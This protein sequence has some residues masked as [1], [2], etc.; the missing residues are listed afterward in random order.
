MAK[1]KVLLPVFPGSNCEYDTVRQFE[2]YGAEAETCIIANLTPALVED[3]VQRLAAAIRQSQIIMLPGGFSGGDEPDG[4]GKFIA[5]FF[6]NPRIKEAVME[7]LQQRDGLMLGI[8]NGFQA[9]V[10]LGLLPYGEICDMTAQSPTL[11]YNNIGRHQS[12]LV[13]TRIASIKS[14]WLAYTEVGDIHAIPISHGEGKFVASP[15]DLERMA[16]GGQI[17]TQYVDMNGQPT[18]LTPYN[19]NASVMAIEGICSPDGRIFG[20]M[21]HS[22]RQGSFVHKNVPGNKDQLLFKAGVDY[23][24][25]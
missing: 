14:P 20:K 3:S 13:N 11:T 2:R 1:P 9:L 22:E 4:S 6:R 19:P 18:M 17:C 16:A 10:K 8:C 23:F 7:L 5:T 15:A 25:L 24:K 21:G 12:M